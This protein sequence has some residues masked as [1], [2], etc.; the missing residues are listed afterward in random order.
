[1]LT[2]KVMIRNVLLYCCLALLP[3]TF[4]IGQKTGPTEITQWQYGKRAAVSLTYDD[5]SINQFTVA[6]PMMNKL[7]LPATFFII[8]GQ[9]PGSVYQGKFIGRPVDEI[10]R[11]TATIPT[12]KENFFERASAVAFLGY[13]GTLQY[14]TNA[15]SIYD[16]HGE[17]KAEEAYKIIDDA[18]LKVRNGE[19]KPKSNQ[20]NRKGV[21]WDQ[22]RSYAAQGHE[23]ASHT[24]T[25]PRLAVLDEPNMIY[26]LEKSKEEILKQLGPRYTFSAEGPYGT[27]NERAM[28]YLLKIY[29]ASRNRMPE[30]FLEELNRSNKMNPGDSKKEYV[31]WQ[32]GAT[33]KTPLPLMKSWIDTVAKHN[34]NWLVLV[35]HGV[36]G[37]GY[38]ALP[39]TLL[40]EYF[41]YMKQKEKD[42][43]IA[44]F[45]DVTKY[46]RERMNTT[47][48]VN[49]TKQ[50]IT[51][52]LNHNLDPS[53]Y[54]LPLTLKSYIPT[55]WK[56]VK[57]KQG[58]KETTVTAQKDERG[59]FVQYQAVPN[60]APVEIS[61]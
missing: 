46:L 59:T 7:S 47:V 27:E 20:D 49:E 40:E 58:S 26:E 9:I 38:E 25:H 57:I 34:N 24:V 3:V 60:S 53:H 61:R 51:V 19:F 52:S 35:F 22:I 48:K 37:I 44:T 56:T 41:Q 10:I 4:A 29:P 32:R 16:E 1:M 31:Q 14:H 17:E 42:L 30:P 6:L 8:T 15:G 39:G 45:G 12:N 18:Y 23:F 13:T 2:I 36:D 21:T 28:E 43:W 11:E 5:G 54:D 50:K 33:T 55:S